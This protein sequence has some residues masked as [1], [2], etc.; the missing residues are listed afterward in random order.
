[1]FSIYCK[2]D[3]SAKQRKKEVEIEQNDRK[4][5]IMF[6][7]TKQNIENFSPNLI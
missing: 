7:S 6:I 1:M 3:C 5:R 2:I 4:I